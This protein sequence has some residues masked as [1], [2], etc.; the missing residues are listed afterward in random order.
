MPRRS[1]R[2]AAQTANQAPNLSIQS[3]KSK[4]SIFKHRWLEC[5][6]QYEFDY[7]VL[8]REIDLSE[9]DSSTTTT[10]PDVPSPSKS[11]DSSIAVTSEED[12]MVLIPPQTILA[13]VP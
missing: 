9:H 6:Q 4:Q 3:V 11:V 13:Y 1:K 2:I 10:T 8:H 12:D 7:V 5:D